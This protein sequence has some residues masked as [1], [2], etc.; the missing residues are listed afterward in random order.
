[1]EVLLEELLAALAFA[2][3]KKAIFIKLNLLNLLSGFW[4]FGV[5]GFWF[6]LV[7]FVLFWFGLVWYGLVCFGLVWYGLVCFGVLSFVACGLLGLVV[8]VLKK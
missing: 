6:V 3:L 5:L 1:M 2:D 8:G 4:G 7:C